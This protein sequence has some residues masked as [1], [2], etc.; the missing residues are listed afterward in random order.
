MPIR[1]RCARSRTASANTIRRFA[2]WC[3]RC[4]RRSRA[5]R[6]RA[7]AQIDD[8]RRCGRIGG[9]DLALAEKVVG[10]GAD[11]G[12]AVT[13]EWD[14]VD[15]PDRLAFWPCDRDRDGAARPADQCRVAAAARI[16]GAGAAA[17]AAAAAE[18]GADRRR[19]RR[20]FVADDGRPLFGDLR[21]DRPERL[22]EHAMPGSCARRLS[23]R[24][25]T[26]ASRRSASCSAIGK[27][28]LQKEAARALVGARGDPDRARCRS[29]ARMRPS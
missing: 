7:S 16:P 14:P 2:R 10:A 24:T 22:A 29:S 21:C 4:A 5:S 19:A 20:L 15:Q 1:R 28:R 3:R 27:D 12:R 17:V 25:E 23:A 26:R 6:R 8:A 18:L 11:T 13:I 9:I